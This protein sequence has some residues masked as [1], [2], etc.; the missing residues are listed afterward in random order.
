M[1]E[2]GL[3]NIR[4][5]APDMSFQRPLLQPLIAAELTPSQRITAGVVHAQEAIK[6]FGTAAEK[7]RELLIW[8]I[9]KGERTQGKSPSRRQVNRIRTQNII[10][11]FD[12]YAASAPEQDTVRQPPDR[13]IVSET[14]GI[15][16]P[17]LTETAAEIYDNARG[18]SVQDE[19]KRITA[20]HLFS[21][22]LPRGLKVRLQEQMGLSSDIKQILTRYGITTAAHFAGEYG[23]AG[24]ALAFGLALDRYTPLQNFGYEIG[25]PVLGVT[26]S[27]WL[28]ALRKNLIANA[29]AL[30][31]VGES[32]RLTSAIPYD[33]VRKL[34]VGGKKLQDIVGGVGYI[35]PEA[36]FEVGTVT[37]IASGHATGPQGVIF[38]AGAN[39]AGMLYEGILAHVTNKYVDARGNHLRNKVIRNVTRMQTEKS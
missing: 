8:D 4:Q 5:P 25:I 24:L 6:Y 33:I 13:Q 23:E 16:L 3:H 34:R 18:W 26:Y 12:A 27:L 32:S 35:A 29:R 11:L 28:P 37:T 17:A 21:K 39:V 2:P 31:E 15:M 7:S 14:L 9:D 38:L 1:R 30:R 19:I 36:L 10:T 22:G 20:A